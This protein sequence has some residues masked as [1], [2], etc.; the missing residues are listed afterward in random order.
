M[1]S[2]SALLQNIVMSYLGVSKKAIVN[3]NVYG[4]GST[5]RNATAYLAEKHKVPYED[6]ALPLSTDGIGFRISSKPKASIND[7]AVITHFEPGTFPVESAGERARLSAN[8]G[9]LAELDCNSMG[10]KVITIIQSAR[11]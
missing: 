3:E 7:G 5:A 6:H 4:F 1:A 10:R 11:E 9:S 8:F 2:T